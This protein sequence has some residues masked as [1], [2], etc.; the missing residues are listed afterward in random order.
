MKYSLLSLLFFF[1][2]TVIAQHNNKAIVYFETDKWQLTDKATK[3]LDS[4]AD[5]FKNHTIDSVSIYGH[6]DDRADSLYNVQLSQKRTNAVSEYLQLQDSVTIK[7]YGENSPFI[8]NI[9]EKSRAL[10]RRVEIVW[11]NN[12][13]RDNGYIKSLADLYKIMARPPQEFCIDNSRDTAIKGEDGTIIYFN[14]NTFDVP[15]DV[16]ECI[17]IR[18][19]EWYKK[20]DIIRDNVT[21]ITEDKEILVSEAMFKLDADFPIMQGKS[22][23]TFAP[24]D[25]IVDSSKT[26][27][28]NRD[29]NDVLHW[30]QSYDELHNFTGGGGSRRKCSKDTVIRDTVEPIC[31]FFFCGIL[32]SV[33][34]RDIVPVVDSVVKTVKADCPQPEVYDYFPKA[35]SF[36]QMKNLPEDSL[37]YY[38]FNTNR[39]GYSNIDWLLKVPNRTNYEVFEKLDK[40]MDIKLIFKKYRS[41]LPF[42]KEE[43]SYL[44]PGAPVDYE[45]WILAFKVEQGNVYL[46][47]EEVTINEE[48]LQKLNLQKVTLDQLYKQLEVFD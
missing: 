48:G 14:A 19:H 16:T 38:V 31:P 44:M 21:T 1:G 8:K 27:Y 10:N 5:Y 33:G 2:L 39:L 34:L 25:T 40:N 12:A 23:T 47:I 28:G 7:Y 11:N 15:E 6:T 22:Y 46:A 41:V 17:S 18:L 32:N 45:A 43:N 9:D 36:V 3:T 24:S 42:S 29:T 26:F 4:L 20:S 30:V 13:G 35:L 37:K